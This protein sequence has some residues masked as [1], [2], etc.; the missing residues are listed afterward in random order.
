MAESGDWKGEQEIEK[1]KSLKAGAP[2]LDS[3]GG[4]QVPP[5]GVCAPC[6][7][8]IAVALGSRVDASDE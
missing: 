5:S 3:E 1:G 7:C 6:P 4:A 2:G 8:Q